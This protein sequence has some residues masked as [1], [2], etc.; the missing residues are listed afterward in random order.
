MRSLRLNLALGEQKELNMVEKKYTLTA[1]VEDGKLRV[2]SENYGFNSMELLG[3]LDWKRED[4]I[5]QVKGNLVPDEVK[6]TLLKD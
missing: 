2:A 4:V 5:S 6:R 3:L 1:I